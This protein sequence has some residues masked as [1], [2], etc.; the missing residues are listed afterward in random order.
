MLAA[1]RW[2]YLESGAFVGNTAAACLSVAQRLINLPDLPRILDA[3]SCNRFYPQGSR[4]LS[5]QNIG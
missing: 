2:F 3:Q 5:S 1:Q 4:K